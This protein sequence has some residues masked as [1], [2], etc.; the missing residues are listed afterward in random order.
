VEI[1]PGRKPP[2][3]LLPAAARVAVEMRHG[4]PIAGVTATL[5]GAATAAGA[6]RLAGRRSRTAKGASSCL[7]LAAVPRRRSVALR[8]P[9]ALAAGRHAQTRGC[10]GCVSPIH[11][12][13]R[14]L[15]AVEQLPGAVIGASSTNVGPPALCEASR[16]ILPSL[17]LPQHRHPRDYS[18][19]PQEPRRRGTRRACAA[20]QAPACAVASPFR[21]PTARRSQEW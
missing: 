19:A 20:H 18:S 1:P 10:F 5:H 2:L 15:D 11:P 7:Q 4:V 9:H 8:Q 16:G 3:H 17:H 12:T 13:G 21:P 6:M 14:R